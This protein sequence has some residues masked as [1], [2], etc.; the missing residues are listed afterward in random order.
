MKTRLGLKANSP[1]SAGKEINVSTKQ[2]KSIIFIFTLQTNI[3]GQGSYCGLLQW[4]QDNEIFL[5]A[6]YTNY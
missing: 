6:K 3:Q 2:R 5:K 1:K 4:C